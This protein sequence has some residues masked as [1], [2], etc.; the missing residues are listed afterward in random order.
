MRY[1]LVVGFCC[2]VY[3]YEPRARIFIDNKLIDEFNI[4]HYNHEKK[5]L[6][7]SIPFS[8]R[9]QE[10]HENFVCKNIPNIS[11]FYE[12]N[13]Y[14]QQEKLKIVIDINND[15]SNFVNGFMSKSTTIKLNHFLFFPLEKK[16]LD[17]LKKIYDKNVISKNISWY[18]RKNYIFELSYSC[19]WHSKNQNSMHFFNNVVSKEKPNISLGGSGFFEQILVKKYGVYVHQIQK[20]FRYKI[21]SYL[22][23]YF[24]NK[25][26][27]YANQ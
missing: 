21:S 8:P 19:S 12:I 9:N 18:Y 5:Y 10:I 23:D 15:D 22:I 11:R 1:L 6:E 24:Y 7:T 13:F 17:K 27:Q 4:S 20:P 2:N 26:N 14:P 25:Y 16:I 3:R